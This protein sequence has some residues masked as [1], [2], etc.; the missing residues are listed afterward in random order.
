VIDIAPTLY[1]LLGIEAPQSFVGVP[2]LPIHGTSLAY[3]FSERSA[4]TRK[5]VQYFEILGDRGIWQEGWKAVARHPKGS[6]FSAD[7]W[8]LYHLAADFSE[9]EDLA[10]REPARLQ[11][12]IERWWD[13][14]RTY[15]VL[16]LDDRDWERGA[17]RLRMNRRTRYEYFGD[18]SRVDRLASPTS[19]TAATA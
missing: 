18:M 3:T 14:A 11:A 9:T 5:S 8:E 19:P 1:E 10:K 2:Q 6:D 17:I 7:V 12:M 4:P 15:G 16:P 13:E